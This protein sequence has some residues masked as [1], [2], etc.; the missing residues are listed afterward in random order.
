MKFRVTASSIIISLFICTLC[1]ALVFA[2]G[3]AKRGYDKLDDLLSDLLA[4]GDRGISISAQSMDGTLAK[5]LVLN[6]MEVAFE[7]STTEGSEYELLAQLDQVELSIGLFGVIKVGLGWGSPDINLTISGAKIYVDNEA[8]E[9]LSSFGSNAKEASDLKL[10][11]IN[12]NVQLSN[13]GVALE[14]SGISANLTGLNASAYVNTSDNKINFTGADLNLPTA[15]VYLPEQEQTQLV[16]TANDIRLSIDEN[17]QITASLDEASLYTNQDS[18]LET[19]AKATEISAL[20]NLAKD[21]ISVATYLNAIDALYL[22]YSAQINGTT[23][24]L[25]YYLSNKDVKLAASLSS[26]KALS[27]DLTAQLYNLSFSGSLVDL[28]NLDLDLYINSANATYQGYGAILSGVSSNLDLTLSNLKTLGYISFDNLNLTGLQAYTIQALRMQ[29]GEID[30]SYNEKSF[31]RIKAYVNGTSSNV[32]VEQF[33]SNLDLSVAL[34]NLTELESAS[35]ALDN[36]TCAALPESSNITLNLTQDQKLNLTIKTSTQLDGSLSLSFVDSTLD[37]R[38]YL[39]NFEPYSLT[40]IYNQLLSKQEII[41]EATN[42]DGSIVFSLKLPEGTLN[43]NTLSNLTLQSVKDLSK[44]IESGLFSINLAVRDLMVDANSYSGAVSFESTLK[45][46]LLEVSTLAVTTNGYRLSYTGAVDYNNL[47]PDGR[48]SLQSAEDGSELAAL[49]FNFLEGTKSYSFSMSSPMLKNTSLYGTLDWQNAD[50]I[51]ANAFIESDKLKAGTIPFKLI[52]VLN[53]LH[54]NIQSQYFSFDGTLEDQ[55]LINLTGAL[56]GLEI[57][58]TS[59]IAVAVDT[60]VTASYDLVTGKFDFDIGTFDTRISDFFSFS[61]ASSVTDEKLTLDKLTITRG[62]KTYAFDGAIEFEYPSIAQLASIAGEGIDALVNLKDKDGIFSIV[63]TVKDQQYYL[64]IK[65][66]SSLKIDLTLL[67]NY[68]YGFYAYGKVNWQDSSGFDFNAQYKDG[69]F[70]FYD[71]SG[72]LGDL[73]LKDIDFNLDSVNMSM[74]FSFTFENVVQRIVGEASRQSGTITLSAQLESFTSSLISLITG[75]DYDASFTLGLKNF[76]LED[77]YEVPDTSVEVFYSKGLFTLTGSLV[78]GTYNSTNNYIDLHIDKSLLFGLDL[79]GYLGTQLDLYASNIY[80]PVPVLFQFADYVIFGVDEATI[81]GDL[82]ISGSADDPRLYGMLYCQSFE[83]WLSY[84]P[85]QTLS[86]KNIAISVQD[87]SLS[88]ATTPVT[89]HSSLD[90]RYIEANVAVNLNL[91]KLNIESFEIITDVLTPVDLWVPLPQG[92]MDFEIRGDAT[93]LVI[94][95]IKNGRPYLE[96]DATASNMLMDFDIEDKQAWIYAMASTIDLDIDLTI[97]SDVEFCYPQKD[98]AFIDFTLSEGENARL[99]YDMVTKTIKTSGSLAFKTGQVYYFQND[100]YITEGSLDLSPKKDGITETSGLTFTLNLSAKLNDYDSSGNKIEIDLV[101]Q[102]ASLDNI[103][104]RFTSSPS[105]SEN[106]ILALLGQTILPSSTFGQ[107]VTV[108]SVASLA[109]AA[110]DAISRLGIIE[111]NSNYSLTA[112]IRESLGFDIFSLRS[113]ILQNIIIDALPGADSNAD[114]S[115]LSKY[116][117]GTSL[118]AGKYLANGVFA[119]ILLKLKSEKNSSNTSNYGH[120]LSK[121]LILDM[122]FSVDWDNPLGTFT[123]FTKPQELS[124]LNILDTIGFSVTK[125]VQF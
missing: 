48:L 92:T 65:A 77:G 117:D 76:S 81:T 102:N 114:L 39:S 66:N 23:V 15:T 4:F 67:G 97:G 105:M 62:D 98:S 21:K 8:L 38:F 20:V 68:K 7:R 101:L 64:E 71:S 43:L 17:L 124:A 24:N 95:G 96:C 75:I 88:I 73:S 30:F 10:P 57:K 90:G 35:V 34:K 25:D 89:G 121:D 107:S 123:I 13:A 111:S 3:F 74:L 56:D 28:E 22:G 63:G 59:F 27:Q 78:N 51:T 41:Q 11:S 29:N 119:Q 50:A 85:S 55:R 103:S 116:L 16:A 31:A 118:F 60:E 106:E 99:S 113:N 54:L 72:N 9:F 93:G 80:F 40:A 70:A 47:I 12:L 58:L 1:L 44:Y 120:F 32:Y 91:N 42:F 86:V 109:A 104:P 52:L 82:L 49:E 115:L 83:M 37:T 61:F 45:G 6:N 53:P 125:R 46:S 84:L 79:K 36:L 33:A 87:H 110:T 2:L 5:A 14:Y 26:V 122:E 112:I 94:Y 100:F 18:S 69:V 108:S 19:L